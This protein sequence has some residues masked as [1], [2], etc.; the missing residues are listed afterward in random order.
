MDLHTDTTLILVPGLRP[1]ASPRPVRPGKGHPTAGLARRVALT[2]DTAL[3]AGLGLAAL[4]V[5]FAL[6]VPAGI[7]V[8]ALLAGQIALHFRR[9]AEE[10]P[11]G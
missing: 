5:T 7:G 2:G 6:S 3:A 9:T 4:A 8:A 10:A 11:R 1:T